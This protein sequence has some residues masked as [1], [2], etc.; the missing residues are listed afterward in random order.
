MRFGAVHPSGL[1]ALCAVS[2]IVHAQ[3]GLL[4]EPPATASKAFHAASMLLRV[5]RLHYQQ[6]TFASV[7]LLIGLD[8]HYVCCA[9]DGAVIVQTKHGCVRH[10]FFSGC[11]ILRVA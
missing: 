2:L 8:Q 11:L 6:A 4:T 9:H 10:L 3:A 1:V 5:H 7:L